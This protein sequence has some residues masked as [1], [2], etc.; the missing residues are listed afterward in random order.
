MKEDHEVRARVAMRGDHVGKK[1][2]PWGK[3]VRGEEGQP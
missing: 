2:W 1:G 3:I